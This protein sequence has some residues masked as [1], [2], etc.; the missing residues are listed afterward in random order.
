MKDSLPDNAARLPFLWMNLPRRPELRRRPERALRVLAVLAMIAVAFTI[1]TISLTS[2][3]DSHKT[4]SPAG[5]LA[6]C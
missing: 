5:R 3:G 6:V 4:S 1:L 2:T